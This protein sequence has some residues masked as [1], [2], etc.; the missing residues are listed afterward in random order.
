M[1]G[2]ALQ[3]PDQVRDRHA[4]FQKQ[5]HHAVKR[6][7]RQDVGNQLIDH[8]GRVLFHLV[9][10]LLEVFAAEQFMGMPA[11]DL[12]KMR[13]QDARR[14]HHGVAPSSARWRSFSVIHLAGKPKAGSRVFALDSHARLCPARWPA[15]GPARS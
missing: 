15:S 3:N 14:I 9:D 2:Q 6:A 13:D 7:H 1:V 5:A 11:D 4:L 8:C 12:A 10:K